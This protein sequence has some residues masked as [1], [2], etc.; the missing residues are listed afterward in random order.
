MRRYS[1]AIAL[2]MIRGIFHHG[3]SSCSARSIWRAPLL[4]VAVLVMPAGAT[5]FAES[6]FF[7]VKA[8]NGTL[9]PSSNQSQIL[10]LLNVAAI[11]LAGMSAQKYPSP[12]LVFTT[13]SNTTISPAVSAQGT[14]S[15]VGIWQQIVQYDANSGM[16]PILRITLPQ[17]PLNP[18]PYATPVKLRN[19]FDPWPHSPLTS[20]MAPLSN[21]QVPGDPDPD[22]ATVVE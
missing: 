15:N 3:G 4:V 16:N 20:P 13:T 2:R 9:T 18:A 5:D 6:T 17:P 7:E 12:A 10:G 19:G 21:F 11:S 22:S 8:V 1:A 14:T